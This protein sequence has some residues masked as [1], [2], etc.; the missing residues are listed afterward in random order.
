MALWGFAE[1]GFSPPAE[2]WEQF[3]GVTQGALPQYSA[4][5]LALLMCAVGKLGP[6]VGCL[7]L[8]FMLSQSQSISYTLLWQPEVNLNA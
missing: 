3:W 6:E 4:Q 5:D 8:S 2:W 1:L 7:R